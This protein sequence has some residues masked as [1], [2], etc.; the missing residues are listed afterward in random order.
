[1]TE[2]EE[3]GRKRLVEQRQ[4]GQAYRKGLELQLVVGNL[5]WLVEGMEQPLVGLEWRVVVVGG[6]AEA[7]AEHHTAE[8]VCKSVKRGRGV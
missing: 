1:L 5:G 6:V 7:E 2:E 4:E 3:G 8:S